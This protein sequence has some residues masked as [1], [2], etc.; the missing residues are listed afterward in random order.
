MDPMSSHFY[1]LRQ[2][3]LLA[4]HG[5]QFGQLFSSSTPTSLFL[6][7]SHNVSVLDSLA[8]KI[9]TLEPSSQRTRETCCLVV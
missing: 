5:Q 6:Q 3:P 4:P 1:H 8:T 9:R 7:Q 2:Q